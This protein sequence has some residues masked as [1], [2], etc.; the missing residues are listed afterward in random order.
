MSHTPTLPERLREVST[1]I[2]RMP[3]PLVSFVPL[4]S[5]A[6]DEID[7]LR[8]QRDA[9]LDRMRMIANQDGV[10]LAL[11]PQWARRIAKQAIKDCE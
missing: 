5:K 1:N 4:L 11:D 6:A 2:R 10:E 8:R 3:M 7:T 9:L